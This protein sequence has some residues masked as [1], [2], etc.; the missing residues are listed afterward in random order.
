MKTLGD[1]RFFVGSQQIVHHALRWGQKRE[2][3][4]VFPGGCINPLPTGFQNLPPQGGGSKKVNRKVDLFSFNR[5]PK[6]RFCFFR[7]LYLL[8]KKL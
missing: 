6:P 1:N 5:A 7:T 4:R 3:H 2:L 8:T